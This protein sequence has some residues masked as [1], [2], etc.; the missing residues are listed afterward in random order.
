[1]V[2]DIGQVEFPKEL[3]HLASQG[4]DLPTGYDY[5]EQQFFEMFRCMY[6]RYHSGKISRD[7]AIQQGRELKDKFRV[8]KWNWDRVE[9][10]AIMRAHTSEARAAYRKNRT[11]ENADALILAIEGVA[12]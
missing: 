2:S 6:D 10:D 12:V 8:F 3:L 9:A 1:M 5:P 7:E 11:L 4:G